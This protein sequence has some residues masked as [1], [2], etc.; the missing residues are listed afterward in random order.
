VSCE[1][2]ALVRVSAKGEKKDIDDFNPEE[3]KK[4]IPP[5]ITPS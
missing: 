4:E 5:P 2:K 1:N 3:T